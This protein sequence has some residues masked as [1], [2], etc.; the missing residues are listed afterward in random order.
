MSNM[1]QE[2]KESAH[3]HSYTQA[4]HLC[5]GLGGGMEAHLRTSPYVNHDCSHVIGQSESRG[6]T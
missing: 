1:G 2:G 4:G 3:H 5:N 6:L